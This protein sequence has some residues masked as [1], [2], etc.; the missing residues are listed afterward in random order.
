MKDILIYF[1]LLLLTFLSLDKSF[2]E[3]IIFEEVVNTVLTEK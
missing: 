2:A 1:A 3:K